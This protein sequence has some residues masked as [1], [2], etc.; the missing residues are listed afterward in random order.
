MDKFI[1]LIILLV[2]FNIFSQALETINNH[3]NLIEC[4]EVSTNTDDLNLDHCADKYQIYDQNGRKVPKSKGKRRRHSAANI[5]ISESL[6]ETNKNSIL[7]SVLASIVGASAHD[8]DKRNQEEESDSGINKEAHKTT[9][10]SIKQNARIFYKILD[11]VNQRR[12][13]S[14]SAGSMERTKSFNLPTFS[15][16]QKALP[17][18]ISP[19]QKKKG[20]KRRDGQKNSTIMHNIPLTNQ[21]GPGGVV[22]F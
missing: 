13:R 6:E 1:L 4:V 20:R 22:I 14:T 10:K 19:A 5:P 3:N 11:R 17:E 18:T 21:E 9:N 8:S 2:S 15:S 16:V 12:R 7:T